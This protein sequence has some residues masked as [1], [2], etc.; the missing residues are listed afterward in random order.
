M[1]TTPL[2]IFIELVLHLF[3][4]SESL[5]LQCFGMV[6]FLFL[7]KVSFKCA[8]TLKVDKTIQTSLMLLQFPSVNLVMHVFVRLEHSITAHSQRVDKPVVF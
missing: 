8:F 3:L 7:Q 5:L 1:D 2:S 4:I 6:V